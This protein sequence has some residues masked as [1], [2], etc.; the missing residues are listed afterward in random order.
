MGSIEK[1]PTAGPLGTNVYVIRTVALEAAKLE[2]AVVFP[3][4]F[5]ST[6]NNVSHHPGAVAYSGRLQRQMLEETTAE[7]ARN[8]CRKILVVNGHSTNMRLPEDFATTEMST[9]NDYV[10]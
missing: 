6:T 1:F 4:Y 3:D 2:Y 8:G 9:P 10:V 5:V 7:M